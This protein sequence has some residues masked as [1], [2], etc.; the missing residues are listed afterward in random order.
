MA[1]T[2]RVVDLKYRADIAQ[3]KSELG[4][5]PGVT[6]K[7]AKSMV[8]ALDKQLK[9]AEKAAKRTQKNTKTT[10]K[11]VSDSAGEADSVLQGLAS[12]LDTVDPKL[13]AAARLAG[14]MSGG[15]EAALRGASG[16][17]PVLMAV[18]AAVAVVGVAYAALSSDLDKANEKM[19]RSRAELKDQAALF[20]TVK[21]AAIAADL[22][23][24]KISDKQADR[25]LTAQ[26][27]SD[28]FRERIEDQTDAVRNA[29]TEYEAATATLERLAVAADNSSQSILAGSNAQAGAAELAVEA[30]GET[31][32][33]YEREARQLEILTAAQTKYAD[34]LGRT[35]EIERFKDGVT[36]STDALGDQAKMME[37][38]D[39]IFTHRAE[40]VEA[41]GDIE[42][43]AIGATLDGEALILHKRDQQLATIDELIEK[44]GDL[45]AAERARGAVAAT[46]EA[47]LSALREKATADDMARSE[48]MLASYAES[49][50][51]KLRDMQT[52]VSGVG[53]S[54]TAWAEVALDQSLSV[55]SDTQE[56]LAALGEN[57]SAAE[58]QRLL[59]ELRAAKDQARKRFGLMKGLQ[60][61]VALATGAVAA[62]AALQP[63]PMGYGNNVLGWAMLGTTIATTGAQIATIAAQQPSFHVG[64]VVDPSEVNARLRAGEAVVTPQGL[65]ALGGEAGLRSLEQGNQRSDQPLHVVWQVGNR[66]LDEAFYPA[67]RSGGRT[68]AATRSTRPRGRRNWNLN[69]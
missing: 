66:V 5:I 4:K 60:I 33:V 45:E 13:G 23:E 27:A 46:A 58:R 52:L 51:D 15:L 22:A 1:S 11:G 43:Q 25:L 67:S 48:A 61:G 26:S 56:A 38:I 42:S 36:S 59:D 55:V 7:E 10:F 31:G 28:L 3:L 8:N 30:V 63:P 62:V 2:E 65:R 40:V 57:A 9:R 53:D 35:Q 54:M 20:R 34:S 17:G 50:A 64:G 39:A 6:D 32:Q 49:Q 29:R 21:D 47:D 14:D 19:E 16:L 41:L 44:T 12:A 37:E 68:R 24:G 69:G 18:G